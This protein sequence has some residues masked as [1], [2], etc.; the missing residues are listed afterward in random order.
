MVLCGFTLV[1]KGCEGATGVG[2]GPLGENRGKQNR[3]LMAKTEEFWGKS[4]L[5]ST[6]GSALW[7]SCG[8]VWA[9]TSAAD[10]GFWLSTFGGPEDIDEGDADM[11]S[12]SRGSKVPLPFI[13]FILGH[14]PR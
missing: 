11:G 1:N 4:C 8:S 7:C 9:A 10:A 13:L 2:P 12:K 3:L 6:T 14:V 5:S